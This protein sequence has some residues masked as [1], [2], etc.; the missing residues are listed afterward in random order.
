MITKNFDCQAM[1]E[2]IREAL[3]D[4]YRLPNNSILNVLVS[5]ERQLIMDWLL[6]KGASA[7]EEVT[8]LYH[9]GNE[10]SAFAVIESDS[11]NSFPIDEEYVIK[12]PKKFTEE[13]IEDIEL[14]ELDF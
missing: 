9:W 13:S 10:T 5:E 1:P 8:I 3:F 11:D 7:S 12:E 6:N 4:S 2:N 14:I